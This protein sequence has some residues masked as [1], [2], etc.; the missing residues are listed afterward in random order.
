MNY[1]DRVVGKKNNRYLREN[2]VQFDTQK[3]IA[4]YL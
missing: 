2:I 4:M 3:H 1:T